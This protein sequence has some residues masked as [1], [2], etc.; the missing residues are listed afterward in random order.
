MTEALLL[1]DITGR[2]LLALAATF[3][4]T[5][6]KRSGPSPEPSDSLAIF[7]DAKMVRAHKKGVPLTDE[8]GKEIKSKVVTTQEL[9]DTLFALLEQEVLD[10]VVEEDV[11]EEKDI[12]ATK[13][14]LDSPSLRIVVCAHCVT[15]MVK[16]NGPVPVQFKKDEVIRLLMGTI[17]KQSGLMDD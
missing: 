3:S 10:D 11:A 15:K 16:E 12:H 9:V 5:G 17:L 4:L 7:P 6:Y 1:E 13:L 2:D 8:L 14:V